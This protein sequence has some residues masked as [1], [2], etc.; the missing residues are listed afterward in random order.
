[1]GWEM[2]FWFVR[3]CVNSELVR[4]DSSSESDRDDDDDNNATGTDPHDAIILLSHP[5]FIFVCFNYIIL[6]L[7][8]FGY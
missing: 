7:L 4:D 8:S 6:R 1:M 3:V 5:P 2:T